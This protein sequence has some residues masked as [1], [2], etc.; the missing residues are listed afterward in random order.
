[1]VETMKMKEKTISL[2]LTNACNLDCIYC[3][4]KQKDSCTMSY[5]RAV[6]II[7][8]EL[9]ADDDT[10]RVTIDFFGGEPFLEFDLMKSIYD[11]IFSREWPKQVKI[12]I[13]TNGTLVHGEIQDWLYE[14]RNNVYCGLSF[15]GNASMQNHNRSNSFD[16]IDLEF[17]GKAWKDP[18]VKMT[19]SDFSLRSLAAGVIFLH[20]KGFDVSCNLAYGLN[21]DEEGTLDVLSEELSK[22]IEFY[23]ENPKIKPCTMLSYDIGKVTNDEGP[24]RKYCGTGT[25]MKSYTTDGQAYPCQF[26]MPLTVG[27][28]TDIPIFKEKYERSEFDEKC[29]QCPMLGICHCCYGSSYQDLGNP[30]SRSES[31]CKCMMVIFAAN[32]YFNWELYKRNRID[33]KR[34]A[35]ILNGIKIVQE[36]LKKEYGNDESS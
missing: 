15:D 25:H 7:T 11:Y 4:E 12:A 2:T 5:E 13:S 30:L 20:S 6:D 34:E 1:M 8:R 22:L 26:F 24:V 21:W 3:Y 10:E 29:Q 14:H 9:L 19:I 16:K 17:Y 28:K 35:N 36:Y 32:S 27:E 31:Y 23:L 33:K 18:N